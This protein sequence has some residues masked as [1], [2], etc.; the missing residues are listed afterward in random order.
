MALWGCG[1]AWVSWVVVV[2]DEGWD[3]GGG[4]RTWASLRSLIGM[5]IVDVI[6]VVGLWFCSLVIGRWMRSGG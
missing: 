4:L 2:G 6:L 1:G 5:P 3:G